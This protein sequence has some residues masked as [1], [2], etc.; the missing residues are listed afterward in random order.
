VLSC[1]RYRILVDHAHAQLYDVGVV[2]VLTQFPLCCQ[3]RDWDSL[4]DTLTAL[5]R[6]LQAR[7][8]D[9]FACRLCAYVDAH[10]KLR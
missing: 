6:T 10:T 8:W 9:S 4:R 1:S 3:A 7:D 5:Q 2:G